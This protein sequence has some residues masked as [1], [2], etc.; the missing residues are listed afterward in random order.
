M[1]FRFYS[2]LSNAQ[3]SRAVLMNKNILTSYMNA[4]KGLI[5]NGFPTNFSCLGY[6]WGKLISQMAFLLIFSELSPASFYEL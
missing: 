4:S 3:V 1:Y 6:V 2:Y 5:P